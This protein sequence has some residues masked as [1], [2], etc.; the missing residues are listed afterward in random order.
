MGVSPSTVFVGA[1]RFSLV[2]F[3]MC[4]TGVAKGYAQQD[5][6]APGNACAYILAGKLQRLHYR[7]IA[8]T[9]THDYSGNWDFDGDG[10]KD[11]LWLIG[12]GGA[13]LYFHLR[14]APSSDGKIQNFNFIQIDMPCVGSVEQIDTAGKRP[15]PVLPQFVVAPFSGR[16]TVNESNDKIYVLLDDHTSISALWRKRGVTSKCLLI[17]FSKGRMVIRNF[18]R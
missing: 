3:F 7:Y 9:Q 6:L 5:T 17:Y 2:I 16:A 18:F 11:S 8:A 10:R 15:P 4:A 13:H 1:V 14:I 12:N